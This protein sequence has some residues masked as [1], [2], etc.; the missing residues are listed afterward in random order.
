MAGVCVTHCHCRNCSV[1][2]LFIYSFLHFAARGFLK[3][4]PCLVSSWPSTS[5]DH[6]SATDWWERGG[7]TCCTVETQTKGGSQIYYRMAEAQHLF[8]QTWLEGITIWIGSMVQRDRLPGTPARPTKPLRHCKIL[9]TLLDLFM[10]LL[11]Y[12]FIYLFIYI[13]IYFYSLTL[14]VSHK[15]VVSR[16]VSDQRQIDTLFSKERPLLDP[17]LASRQYE[18]RHSPW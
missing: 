16:W 8:V 15:C 9:Q 3:L 7:Q 5:R 4:V 14:E 18:L 17:P 11:I 2:Y 10:W 13:S 1:A 12:L 6:L